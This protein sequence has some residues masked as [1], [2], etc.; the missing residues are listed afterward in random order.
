[1]ELAEENKHYYLLVLHMFM[2][3]WILHL[4]HNGYSENLA[5]TI[6]IIC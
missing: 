3:S 6:D 1:M 4:L 5:S 2:I